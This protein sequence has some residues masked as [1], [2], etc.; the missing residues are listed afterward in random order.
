MPVDSAGNDAD[1]FVRGVHG[2]S[3]HGVRFSRPR[4]AISQDGCI[5]SIQGP[6][7]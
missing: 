1:I 2:S 7:N 6:I 4:L 3:A 5:V